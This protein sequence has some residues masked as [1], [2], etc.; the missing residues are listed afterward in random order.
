MTSVVI[1]GS[2]GYI[3]TALTQRLTG[4]GRSLKL[5]SRSWSKARSNIDLDLD[6][7]YARDVERVSVDLRDECTWSG[8]L[9]GAD[10]VIHLSSR[11]DLLAAEANPE[12]DARLNLDP[13]RSLVRA[14]ERAG[15]R[16]LV[17]FASAVTIVGARHSNPVD[18]NTPDKPCSVYD[19]NKL[20]C[21]TIL[22][23]AAS[24]GILRACSLRLA[25][26]YGFGSNSVNS[27]RG[28]LNAMMKRAI[29]GGALTLYG[30]GSYV[31]D[32]VHLDDVVQ[33][34]AAALDLGR[35]CE[36]EHYVIA[37]GRGHSLAQA[38]D[39][40]VQETFRLTGQRVEVRRIPEP[41]DM[42]PIERRN[43]TGNARFFQDIS[44]WRPQVELAA[45]IRDYVTR[46][47]QLAALNAA[48]E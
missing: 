42:H 4:K 22:K 21:E 39:L 30:D 33:A 43:F 19:C 35:G 6:K 10:A 32:F 47:G 16:P 36:G 38:F 20:V 8:L 15:S 7:D 23:N 40:I 24:R 28:I 11:T 12:E 29:A 27:N 1:T 9:D 34:F 44:G 5:V 26:V 17:I 25:N 37:T 48:N 41:P 3:G 14:A 18:E 2:S 13:V 46:A 45:G 31:R